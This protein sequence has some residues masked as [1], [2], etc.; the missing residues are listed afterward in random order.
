[1]SN[2]ISTLEQLLEPL[3]QCLTREVAERISHLQADE[4]IQTRLATLSQKNAEGT[5][6]DEE[7]KELNDIVHASSVIAI[8]Q[9]KARK[10]LK[11]SRVS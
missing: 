10:V 5:I 1:M 3:E 2:G 8:L 11:S 7:R 4:S 6:S 9:A